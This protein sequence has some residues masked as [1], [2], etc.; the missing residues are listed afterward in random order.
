MEVN[1]E[2]HLRGMAFHEAGHA[3]VAWLLNLRVESVCIR[4]IGAG[5]SETKTDPPDHLPLMDQLATL[6][7]GLEAGRA[8][9]CPLHEHAGDR[10]RLIAITLVL[11]HHEGLASDEIQS[12]L[13]AG[14][15]R[16]REL[17]SEHRERVIRVAEHLRDVRQVDAV[18]FLGLMSA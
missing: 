13:A 2:D 9:N 3:V 7:A 14:H 11:E 1:A 5:N 4:E 12:H 16:A 6:A 15:A 10:D 18:E 8:F 17:L